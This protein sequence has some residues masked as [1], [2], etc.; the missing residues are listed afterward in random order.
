MMVLIAQRRGYDGQRI[1][2]DVDTA[3][4]AVLAGDFDRASVY[5]TTFASALVN[6]H[7]PRVREQLFTV[8]HKTLEE[9]LGISSSRESDGILAGKLAKLARVTVANGATPGEE[10]AARL[11]MQRLR[12]STRNR[13]T[14]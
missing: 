12:N 7:E 11:A 10:N 2:A 14:C 9:W 6:W 3:I 5:G 4:E 8:A 13:S 1:R